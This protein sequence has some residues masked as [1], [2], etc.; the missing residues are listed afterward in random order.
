M[1]NA[2]EDFHSLQEQAKMVLIRL[3]KEY[4]GKEI[5]QFSDYLPD[6]LEQLWNVRLVED[7][8]L[9]KLGLDCLCEA[10]RDLQSCRVLYSKKIYAHATYHFQQAVE[11]ATKGYMWGFG[12][13]TK[14]KKSETHKSPKLFLMVLEKTSLISWA[15]QLPDAGIKTIIGKAKQIIDKPEHP[16]IA[17]MSYEEIDGLISKIDMYRDKTRPMV[18]AIFRQISNITSIKSQPPPLLQA[19]SATVVLFVLSIITLPH[20]AYT[21]YPDGKVLP[22]DYTAN[23]GVVRTIPKM[24][25]YLEPEIHSLKTV[26]SRKTA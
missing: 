19:L 22:S 8:E 4:F 20:E 11:K 18:E 2:K 17:L 26:I 24:T 14:D 15:S 23:L 13:L 10:E 7:Q 5:E 21:R 16:D 9:R 1:N 12:L 25:K 3:L 6:L